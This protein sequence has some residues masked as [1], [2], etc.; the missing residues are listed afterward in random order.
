MGEDRAGTDLKRRNRRVLAGALGVV[1][2]MVGLSFAAVPFYR[3]F[4]RAT[5]LGGTTQVATA[6]SGRVVD[7]LVT[8]RFD[9]VVNGDLKW[10]FHPDQ[11]AATVKPGEPTEIHYHARNRGDQAVVGTAT[12]NVT[13]DKA[14]IYFDKIQCFCFTRQRLEPGQD[15]DLGVTFFVDPAMADDPDM[16]DVKTITLSYTFFR[17]ADQTAAVAE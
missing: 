14:G 4:C 1:A 2:V 11:T 15:A 10:D 17:A 5:G 16:A 7:R 12:F 9:A 6:A 3:L 13:P 8:V